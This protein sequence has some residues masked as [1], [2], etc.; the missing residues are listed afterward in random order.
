M[1]SWYTGRWWVGCYIWYV[2]PSTASAPITVLVYGLL[3]CG[4]NVFAQKGLTGRIPSR[5]C[6]IPM[7][8]EVFIGV[9][10]YLCKM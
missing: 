8:V 7:K 10:V 1:W 9:M 5:R 3:L 4:I 2:H 6:S